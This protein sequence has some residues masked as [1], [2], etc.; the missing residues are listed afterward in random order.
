MT[1][2][3]KWINESPDL[4]SVRNNFVKSFIYWRFSVEFFP[5]FFESG[6]S[7]VSRTTG[8]VYFPRCKQTLSSKQF[9]KAFVYLKPDYYPWSLRSKRFREV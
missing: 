4:R 7:T 9:L 6:L 3:L 1:V 2:P 5:S 8:P